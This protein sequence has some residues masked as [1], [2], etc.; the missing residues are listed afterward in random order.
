MNKRNLDSAII[1][2]CEPGTTKLHPNWIPNTEQYSYIITPGTVAAPDGASERLLGILGT[3]EPNTFLP[4]SI[5]TSQFGGRI[6]DSSSGPFL[7]LRIRWSDVGNPTGGVLLGQTG[8][9]RPGGTGSDTN[10]WWVIDDL[11][12]SCRAY[13]GSGSIYDTWFFCTTPGQ[14]TGDSYSGAHT[15]MSIAGDSKA[16]SAVIGIDPITNTKQL[17]IT[18]EW[19]ATTSG[20]Q[21]WLEV[22]KTTLWKI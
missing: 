12:F 22:G 17:V 20:N 3:F 15:S 19:S 10:R 5:I 1:P 18:A 7:R 16:N 4:T 11:L 8:N 2:A 21:I 14:L 6:N 9:N 13:S